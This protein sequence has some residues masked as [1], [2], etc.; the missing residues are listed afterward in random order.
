MPLYCKGLTN[1]LQYASGWLL[2]SSVRSVLSSD[3]CKLNYQYLGGY[4]PIYHCGGPGS[5]PGQSVW[6]LW[7]TMWQQD[8][9]FPHSTSVIPCQNGPDS[10]LD[11]RCSYQKDERAT[12]GGF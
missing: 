10:I 3:I 11:T 5:I 6:N 1:G 4:S 8:E 9:F 12:T 7:W 2:V